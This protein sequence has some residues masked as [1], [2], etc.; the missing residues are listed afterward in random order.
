MSD[1]PISYEVFREKLNKIQRELIASD[2]SERD[3]IR[4]I[5]T[6]KGKIA[7]IRQQIRLIEIERRNNNRF[8]R[9]LALETIRQTD[10]VEIVNGSSRVRKTNNRSFARRVKRVLEKINAETT[11]PAPQ[12]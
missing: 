11:Q 5:A 2:P 9:E 1:Q 10:G 7:A 12:P 3:C 6:A 8:L 4:R